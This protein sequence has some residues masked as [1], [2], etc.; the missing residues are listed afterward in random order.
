MSWMKIACETYDQNT[1][2]IANFE[3]PPYLCPVAHVEAYCQIEVEMDITGN[4]V[5]ARAI[6]EK[7]DAET[8]IP[9]TEES[10]SRSSGTAPHPLCDNLTYVAGDFADYVCNKKGA[11]TARE[12]FAK[13][14]ESLGEW[15]NSAFSS[16]II[17]AVYLYLSRGNLMKDLIK[18]ELVYFTGDGKLSGEKIAGRAYDK[19]MVRFRVD[20]PEGEGACWRNKELM[21][22]FQ[23]FYLRKKSENSRKDV[24]YV[25][26]ERAVISDNHPKGILASSYG[27]KLISS[28][29]ST[30]F[31][32][33]GR[34]TTGEEAYAVSYVASQKAHNALRWLAKRQGLSV[35]LQDKRTY[36]CWN[37]GKITVP[38]PGRDIF[39]TDDDERASNVPAT[40]PGYKNKLERCING[41]KNQFRASDDIVLMV[42]E[43][44]TTGRLSI[45][46]YNKMKAPDFFDRFQ[47]W[48]ESCCWQ[49]TSFNELGTPRQEIK[50]PTIRQI[51]RC[52]FGVEWRDDRAKKGLPLYVNENLMIMQYQ[53]LFH[54]IVNGDKLPRDFVEAIVHQIAKP[55]ESFSYGNRERILSTACALIAKYYYENG[56]VEIKMELDRENKD[57]SYCYGRLLAVYDWAEYSTYRP[58]EIRPTN[59]ARLQSNYI[60]KPEETMLVLQQK[61][62]P[63][64]AKD[65]VKSQ[66]FIDEIGDIL[67]TMDDRE[68]SGAL[69]PCFVN[70]YHLERAYLKNHVNK[71]KKKQEEIK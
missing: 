44:A 25:T 41:Y 10:A 11:N 70:G 65:V 67:K 28:N 6:T 63:Y 24:C 17:E 49:Y 22:S 38:I 39:G 45:I 14:M 23:K 54:C 2:M 20:L 8:I 64:Y 1:A 34:F 69:K 61:I 12:R 42:L 32:Y 29:D 58:D 48:Y 59:A 9:V 18:S 52:A 66:L 36:I 55:P 5:N 68:K 35:G 26:G 56:E 31:T 21:E 33:R 27:A 30:D 16:P 47:R 51:I 62:Q 40:M 71:N 7:K 4:F 3:D 37:P 57:R 60:Q 53:R 15:R 50:S 13:Y 43:A 19:C 46:Y